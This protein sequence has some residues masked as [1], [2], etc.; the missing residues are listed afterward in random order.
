MKKFSDIR[1]LLIYPIFFIA[2]N[3]SEKKDSERILEGAKNIENCKPI[4][5]DLLYKC[6]NKYLSIKLPEDFHPSKINYQFMLVDYVYNYQNNTRLELKNVVEITSF[7]KLNNY[8]YTDKNNFYFRPFMSIGK[9]YFNFVN[10][11]SVI[12]LSQDKDTLYLKNETLYK[13]VKI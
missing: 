2:C 12:K 1:F 11:E 9:H 6:D 7:Q 5:L 10:K 13:G 8:Y 4:K 3:G